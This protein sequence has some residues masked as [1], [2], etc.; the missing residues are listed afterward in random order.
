MS[1][2]VF[3]SSSSKH[4]HIACRNS[5]TRMCLFFLA[6]GASLDLQNDLGE[7]AFDGIQDVHGACA[8]A[9]EFNM[10]L[11]TIARFEAPTVICQ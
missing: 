4:R 7:M 11:R 9:V 5:N 1:H 6:H 8:R 2:L 3:S 10:K